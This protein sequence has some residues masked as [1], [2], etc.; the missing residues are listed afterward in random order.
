[1]EF[2]FPDTLNIQ[3]FK[4]FFMDNIK[5]NKQL[6]KSNNSEQLQSSKSLRFLKVLYFK[7]CVMKVS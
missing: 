4:K 6:Y 5:K 3:N 7:K 1:M 2:F